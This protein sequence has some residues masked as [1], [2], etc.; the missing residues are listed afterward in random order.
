[1]SDLMGAP[2]VVLANGQLDSIHGKTTHGLVRGPSRFEIVAVV[3]PSTS[4][5]G[6]DAGTWVDGRR[7]GIPVV[8]SVADALTL[9]P[10]PNVCVIGVAT[11]GG[12]L[13][14]DVRGEVLTA[15]REGLTVVNGLHAH[16]A[17]DPEI[18]D[19]ALAGN[20]RLIDFR[21]AKAIGDLRFWS[22]EIY[23]IEIPR[24]AVLGID[25]AIGKRTTAGF[26]KQVLADRGIRADMIYT[27]QTGFLQGYRHGFFFDAT[28][29]DFVSGEL[30]GAI[31]D[32]AR[33]SSPELI[34]IEGQASL[35][36]PSGP[37]G[38]EL[39]LSAAAHGAVL[40]VAPGRRDFEGLEREIPLPSVA[41]EIALIKAYG[42]P[43]L[44]LGVHTEGL[45]SESAEAARAALEAEHG[46]P[47][48][49]PVTDGVGRMVDVL[50]DR[51]GLGDER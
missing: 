2:A 48:V 27:G 9:A 35:R 51:F 13:P 1:M 41:E 18:A 28:P 5:E 36:N 15:A 38:S 12:M 29:N 37:C 39:L 44:A 21:R 49:L 4:S 10:R 14:P 32:C 34:L 17:D 26:L 16:L 8:G 25:C 7:R 33:E 50:I 22:G 42:V 31:L 43:V 6:S 3:D 19:A 30:E 47:A 24:I 45:D 46:V 40:L 23:D 11:H 20:A